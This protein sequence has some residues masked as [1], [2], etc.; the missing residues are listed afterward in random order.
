MHRTPMGVDQDAENIL[1]S[2]LRCSLADG[3]GGSMFAT[4]VTDILFGTPTPLQSK[5]NLGVL[6]DDQVNL[7]VH[8]HE[9]LLSE[10]IAR[11]GLRAPDAGYA[12][13][14]AGAKG[15]NLAGICCTANEILMRHG[16]PL[17]GNF[18]QQELA[19]AHR[20]RGRDD[21][22]RAVHYGRRWSAPQSSSTPD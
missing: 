3:W 19:I 6:Q 1:K 17:A 8:G 9:P 4:D 5:I 16:V 20:R 12:K 15:I 7:L 21:R 22:R 14:K 13:A 18:L 10:T 2:A 11:R